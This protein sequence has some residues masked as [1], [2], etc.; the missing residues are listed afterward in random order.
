MDS[1]NLLWPT[2]LVKFAGCP[3]VME[4]EALGRFT[5]ER[6]KQGVTSWRR[7]CRSHKRRQRAESKMALTQVQG[8]GRELGVA[9]PDEQSTWTPAQR[10]FVYKRISNEM[11]AAS[12]YSVSPELL[13]AKQQRERPKRVS[14]VASPAELSAELLARERD[15]GFVFTAERILQI[16]AQGE[17]TTAGKKR[18]AC[19]HC[20]G[21]HLSKDCDS[22]VA[23]QA[24]AT[25]TAT[26][27]KKARKSAAQ[28]SSAAPKRVRRCGLCS[29][30]GHNRRT[31][32]NREAESPAPGPAPLTTQATVRTR[33][34]SAS[35]AVAVDTL[36]GQP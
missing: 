5:A 36:H 19:S 24:A 3:T 32:P 4:G 35:A 12:S 22:S 6:T 1:M 9:L 34:T 17:I 23:P 30:A 21:N 27:P 7:R 18:K 2:Q 10:R 26:P 20:H 16:N 13:R 28:A 8:L 29:A 25:A 33:A 11:P 15:N 31:C 14:G